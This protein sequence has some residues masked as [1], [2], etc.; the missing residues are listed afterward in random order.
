MWES[1]NI[2]LVVFAAFIRSNQD[3]SG[4]RLFNIEYLRNDTRYT[5]LLKT[6][7][8]KWY[9]ACWIVPLLMTLIDLQVHS[10]ILSDN[11]YPAFPVSVQAN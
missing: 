11:K 5:W 6:T 10:A 3:D 7:N 1:L 8:R 4:D 9:V 2:I